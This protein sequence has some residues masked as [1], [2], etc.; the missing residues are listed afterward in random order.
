[1]N[2]EF[3]PDSGLIKTHKA[4]KLASAAYGD[5]EADTGTTKHKVNYPSVVEQLSS[6]WGLCHIAKHSVDDGQ[7]P[8]FPT[9]RC[10]SEAFGMS[11]STAHKVL[12]MMRKALVIHKVNQ[13]LRRK[14][15][16]ALSRYIK[17]LKAQRESIH[18][19][20]KFSRAFLRG[21]GMHEA[22]IRN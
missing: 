20:K 5:F 3:E 8:N 22:A 18:E 21:R 4:T 6:G 11:I 19:L 15:G 14:R 17:R 16:D 9:A 10:I 2:I 1:M 13:L 7:L 12:N